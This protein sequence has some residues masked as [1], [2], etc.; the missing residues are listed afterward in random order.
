MDAYASWT[1]F[2]IFV[3]ILI[4]ISGVVLLTYKK[5]E[6]VV[7]QR[8]AG[9]SLSSVPSRPIPKKTDGKSVADDMDSERAGLS[10][11]NGAAVWDVG[12]VSDEEDEGAESAT[13]R[14]PRHEGAPNQAVQVHSG[15][16]G[17]HLMS[18]HDEED[19][20]HP[21]RDGR[22]EVL[23]RR[24]SV[25]SAMRRS[26]EGEADEFGEFNDGLLRTR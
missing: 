22:P 25:S 12:D 17:V 19:V 6:K 11:E 21:V 15:E 16:E 14:A 5:P 8:D 4:L 13:P 20:R 2:L 18:T 24:R 7:A 10:G 9:I 1:L 23:S 3:S 26:E